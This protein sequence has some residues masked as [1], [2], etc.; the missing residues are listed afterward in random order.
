MVASIFY[1][2]KKHQDSNVKIIEDKEPKELL[3]SKKQKI[4]AECLL[5]EAECLFIES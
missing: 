1:G 3:I 5:I 4:E 2:C